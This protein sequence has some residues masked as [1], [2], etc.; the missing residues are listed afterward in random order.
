M[1]FPELVSE[2]VNADLGAVQ[3]ES[4]VREFRHE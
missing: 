4:H 3:K 1:G 2:M